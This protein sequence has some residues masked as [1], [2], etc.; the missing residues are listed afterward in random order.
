MLPINKV[1]NVNDFSSQEFK[2][3]FSKYDLGN[4]SS[5]PMAEVSVMNRK[6]WE[7]GMALISLERTGAINPSSEIL[8]IGAA[9][10]QTISIL[11][12]LVKRVFATDIYLAP[13]TWHEW[14][15]N[16][17]LLDARKYMDSSYNHKRVV[18][19][20]VDG[21]DLPYEDN[22]FDAIFSCSSLEHFGD[23]SD[24]RK[25]IEEACRVLKPGG[26]AAISSEYKIE[27]DGNGF[28][29]VQLFDEDRLRRVWLDGVNWKLEGKL[30][31]VLDDTEY[32]DF[33]RSIHDKEYQ[34]TAHPHIK[35]DNGA[36]KWTSVHMT[37]I[38]DK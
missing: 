28:H 4:I 9:K 38:K 3:L 8:G 23:E 25:A 2:D 24:I 33:E 5:F 27:G 15:E 21:R 20:H 6:T 30:D 32:V 13:G 16:D 37:F 26:V 35:L 22:S 1:A 7:I 19:Q 36:Y 18:W 10:E 34:K 31:L 14:Y 12:N 11:S 29:N 17:I